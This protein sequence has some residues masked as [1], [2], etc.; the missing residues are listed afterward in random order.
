MFR[1]QYQASTPDSATNSMHENLRILRSIAVRTET[2]PIR[3]R[4]F[5]P[6]SPVKLLSNFLGGGSVKDLGSLQKLSFPRLGDTPVISP[7]A[8]E[9]TRSGSRKGDMTA[10]PSESATVFSNRSTQ[11]VSSPFA[12]LEETFAVYLGE[13]QTRAG[14]IVGHTLR[15]RRELDQLKVNEVYNALRMYMLV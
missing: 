6:P 3:S 15:L 2:D 11:S 4:G 13:L 7:P 1:R 12:Q 14:D 8:W 10:Q 5:R 9:L